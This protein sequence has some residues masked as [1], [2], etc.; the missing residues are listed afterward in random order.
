[1]NNGVQNVLDII[2]EQG[3]KHLSLN[4]AQQIIMLKLVL[5]LGFTSLASCNC[6]LVNEEGESHMDTIFYVQL[7]FFF[8]VYI[9]FLCLHEMILM[10][11]YVVFN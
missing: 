10:W 9:L 5:S 1:M 11:L 8:Q 6:L 4:W 2:W 3:L 7:T